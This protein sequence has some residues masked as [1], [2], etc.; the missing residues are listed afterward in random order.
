[1][2]PTAAQINVSIYN[3]DPANGNFGLLLQSATWNVDVG[4]TM[5]TALTYDISGLPLYSAAL[6]LLSFAADGDSSIHVTESLFAPGDIF[7]DSLQVDTLTGPM[8]DRHGLD[9]TR[10]FLTINK[11]IGLEGHLTGQATLSTLTQDFSSVPEPASMALF[12]AGL[13]L[14]VAIRRRAAHP[15]HQ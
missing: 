2:P 14:L 7:I 9:P 3:C 8:T 10:S 5:D 12:G 6:R 15:T 11:D 1:M 4:Q 13:L